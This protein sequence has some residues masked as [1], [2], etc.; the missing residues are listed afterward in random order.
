[1][2]WQDIVTP[3]DAYASLVRSQHRREAV[4]RARARRRQARRALLLPALLGAGL[5]AWAVVSF[6]D[7]NVQALKIGIGVLLVVPLLATFDLL[8]ERR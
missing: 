3:D 6:D 8:G 1:M 2:K 5:L 7:P 4:A